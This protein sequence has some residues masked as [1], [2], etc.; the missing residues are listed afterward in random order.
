MVDTSQMQHDSESDGDQ[1]RACQPCADARKRYRRAHDRIGLDRRPPDMDAEV[2]EGAVERL[3]DKED[4]DGD[5]AKPPPGSGSRAA[6]SW[7]LSSAAIGPP[8]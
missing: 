5:V 8:R 2:G 4:D 3:D 7:A 6:S 1:F